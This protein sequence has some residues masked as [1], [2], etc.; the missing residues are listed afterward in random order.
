MLI[1]NLRIK[2][3]ADRILNFDVRIMINQNPLYINDYG[4]KKVELLDTFAAY[5]FLVFYRRMD[6]Q[7]SND[8]D[9]ASLSFI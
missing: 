9:H 6:W 7:H 1:L 5:F 8:D 2:E 4:D 3:I